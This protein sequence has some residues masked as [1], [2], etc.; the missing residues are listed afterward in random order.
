STQIG[1]RVGEPFR[2]SATF[3]ATDYFDILSISN[4]WQ[5][6]IPTANEYS[7]LITPQI[8]YLNFSLFKKDVSGDINRFMP[9]IGS[10]VT[11][12]TFFKALSALGVRYLVG[13]S[14][15]PQA[16]QQL[17]PARTFPRRQPRGPY[18]AWQEGK[19]EVYEFPYP[20]VGDYSPTHVV[21]SDSA[22][23]IVARLSGPD[24]DFRRDVVLGEASQPLVP[25]ARTTPVDHAGRPALLRRERRHL[26]GP[27][28]PAVLQLPESLRPNRADRP[29]QPPLGRRV[30]LRQGRYRY[31]AWLR[32]ALSRVPA[33]R[34]GR[35]ESPQ[36]GASRPPEPNRAR[37]GR[38]DEA[39]WRRR[40]SDLGV[41]RHA[42][43]ALRLVRPSV[44][45]VV[46]WRYNFLRRD[47]RAPFLLRSG[48]WMGVSGA[49]MA[50][51]AT[52]AI[53]E[54][55][56]QVRARS[57]ARPC[58]DGLPKPLGGRFRPHLLPQR[59]PL[60]RYCA[61]T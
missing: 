24:F 43:L 31:L 59:V 8:F 28:P 20:N 7:Q 18:Y 11:F 55:V 2:G 58:Q 29:R 32:H 57:E 10:G 19:W 21:T 60:P 14:L 25:R 39:A 1:L 23:A 26:T 52:V 15:F 16:D 3:S 37:L 42:K 34:L 33:R 27:A 44:L 54:E 41:S 36:H 61:A 45:L 38:H 30:V 48:A 56:A 40:H 5:H 6:G 46:L 35:R 50:A 9:W 22:A 47:G 51:T 12:E 53:A 17:M 4:L 13:Y 49:W